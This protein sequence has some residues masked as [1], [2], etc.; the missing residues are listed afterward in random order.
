MAML[1]YN[2]VCSK[3]VGTACFCK[4]QIFWSSSFDVFKLHVSLNFIFL[5]LCCEN[6]V[7]KVTWLGLGKSF[8]W[9]Y[10]HKNGWK[11][12]PCLVI[13]FLVMLLQRGPQNVSWSSPILWSLAWHPSRAVSPAGLT[14]PQS[15]PPFV[16]TELLDIL[17]WNFGDI[18]YS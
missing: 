12:S 10:H 4:P 1:V 11:I 3:N 8:D 13:D 14:P 5:I 17:P 2:P 15:P 16:Q 7:F 6:A 9:I 18:H